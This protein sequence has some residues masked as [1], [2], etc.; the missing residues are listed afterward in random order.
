[1]AKK[2]RRS[3]RI[4]QKLESTSK[5]KS[6]ELKCNCGRWVIGVDSNAA[7]ITCWECTTRLVKPEVRRKVSEGYPKGWDEM[8]RFVHADGTVFEMGE[9]VPELRG[10]F[11]PTPIK[12]PKERVKSN[13]PKTKAKK[14]RVK[15]DIDDLSAAKNIIKKQREKNKLKKSGELK[16][17]FI[18]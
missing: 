4:N 12:T 6:I 11:Q 3:K 18:Q 9:E 10:K 5:L 17:G 1:M 15:K 16:N 13:K 7:S 2:A 8:E 14:K